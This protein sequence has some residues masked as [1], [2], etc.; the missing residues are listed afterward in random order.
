MKLW[1]ISDIHLSFLPDGTVK[2][3]MDKR[4]WSNGSPNYVGYLDKIA[5][6]GTNTIAE[7]DIVIFTGDNTHDMQ[8]REARTS[9]LWVRSK[10]KGTLVFIPGNHDKYIK[11]SELRREGIGER[12][13][14]LDSGEIMSIG[15]YT[16]GCLNIHGMEPDISKP[17]MYDPYRLFAKQL[18]A[19]AKKEHKTPIFLSHYPVTSW[20]AEEL[21]NM[22]VKVYL[23]GHI[24]CT[25]SKNADGNDWQWYEANA[26]PTDDK[27]INGCYFSTGTTDILLNRIG[28][29]FKDITAPATNSSPKTTKSSKDIAAN[30]F[31][32]RLAQVDHFS[33]KDPFNVGNTIEGYICRAKGKMGGSLYITHVNGVSVKPQI[34]YATPKLEYPYINSHS[35]ELLNFDNVEMF[36]MMDKWNG[37]N[38]FFYKYFDNNGTMFITAKTKGTPTLTD[39][40]YG[41]FFSLTKEVLDRHSF[42]GDIPIIL[43]DMVRDEVLGMS[44]E[45]C[46]RKEPHLVKYDFDIDLKPLFITYTDGKIKPILRQNNVLSMPVYNSKGLIAAAIK[47]SQMVDFQKNEVFRKLN[48]IPH[49]YE[50]EHFATEGKVL[51]TLDKDGYVYNRTLYK[52]KPKDIEEVHWQTFDATLEARVSEAIKKLK[53]AGETISEQSLSSELDMGPKEWDKFG[54]KVMEYSQISGDMGNR[55]VIVLCGLPGSGKSTLA[56]KLEEIGYVRVNQDELGS[57]NKCKELMAKSLREKKSIVVDRCNFDINQRKSWIDL[58]AKYNVTRVH[59]VIVD[60]PIEICKER[61]VTRQ[62]HPTVKPV[63]ESK[64]LVDKFND[65]WVDPSMAEGFITVTRLSNEEVDEY[66][67]KAKEKF[68]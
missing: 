29:I 24:H 25:S 32:C 38:V 54:Q 14:L 6:F 57:R 9:F 18:V 46:G 13:Y 3:P 4:S 39:S 2:K 63:E 15:A 36:V 8:H 19:Q 53:V 61:I 52:I 1:H 17:E 67:A 30:A 65:I 33:K 59:A 22:G 55:E 7:E 62:N 66:V 11:F 21:G 31:S 68:N 10:V 20:F 28:Q 48:N 44:F 12:A 58:A 35:R 34:I 16:F 50:Y 51:Y 42:G 41:N 49:K 27:T 56:K 37:M 43:M 45:L 60:T 5:D 64:V 47:D 26:A 40:E 23:S